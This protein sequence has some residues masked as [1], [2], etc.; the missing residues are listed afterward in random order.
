MRNILFSICIVYVSIKTGQF[1][2]KRQALIGLLKV[3]GIRKILVL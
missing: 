2:M 3:F 1:L